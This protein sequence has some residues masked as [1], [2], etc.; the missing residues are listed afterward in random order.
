MKSLIIAEKPIVARDLARVLGKVPKHSKGEYFENDNY[1][2]ASAV[3]H[4]VE[5][6]MPNDIDSKL[7]AWSLKTLPILP[8]RFQLKP[9]DKTKAKFAELK[10]LLR[11]ADIDNVINACDAGREGELIFEYIYEL[12]GSKLPKKRLWMVSMTTDAI[13]SAFQQLREGE[14][15]QPLQHA[16]RCRSESDWLIGINGTRALTKSMFGMQNVATVGR[17][18]TPTLAMVVDREAEIRA[19][20]SRDFWRVNA[21]FSIKSG[22]YSGLYQKP[23]FKKGEDNHD[24][25][26]RLWSEA[27]ADAIAVAV[28]GGSAK[29]EE[30]CKRTRQTAPRL[31]DLTTLQ[32]EANGRFGFPA[33]KTLRVAQALYEKHKVLTYPRT[34]SKALPEDYGS[35]VR[36]VLAAFSGNLKSYANK[37]LSNNW[38]IPANKRIFNNAQVTDHFAI[39]PTGVFKAA[40]NDDESKLFDM[41]CRRFLAVFY[42]SAEYD[43]TTRLSIVGE[44][45]FKTEGKVLVESGW[46]EVMERNQK[47]DDLPALGKAD[48]DPAQAKIEAVAVEKDATRPPARYTEAT[49]LAAMETAGKLVEDEE[50]ADAMKESGLGTPATRAAT[51]EHL[52][53]EKYMLREG[54][55]LSPTPKAEELVEL[56][57]AIGAETLTSPVMTGDWEHRLNLMERGKL[58][59]EH[60][61]N[62][63]RALTQEL[64]KR[65]ISFQEKDEDL[66]RTDFISPTDGKPLLDS[67][68]YYKSQDGQLLINKNLGN[69]KLEDNEVR[70]LLKEGRIGPLDGF[71]SKKGRAFSAMLIIEDGKAK[72]DFGGDSKNG[73]EGVDLSEYPVI[74]AC[75]LD[76]APIHETANA[77]ICANYK[78]GNE[79]CPF[80][81]GRII[82]GRT[83]SQEEFLQLL[84]DKKTPLLKGFRSNRTKRLF[85]A[86]LVLDEKGKVGFD[87]PPRPAKKPVARKQAKAK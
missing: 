68:R 5:L 17:V 42:P 54:R 43:V 24:R 19:F 6:F 52:L 81:V 78:P 72:F 48:G 4:L 46:L 77:F 35:T 25:A 58:S 51:I 76:G 40:L 39:I 83:I 32:R 64:V 12:S 36:D 74:A 82:L 38:V 50:L 56:L 65:M 71:R 2:I 84:N 21:D 85:D 9:I 59:R 67:L 15:M 28:R 47:S 49:L 13:K 61:M 73:E 23:G 10:R 53:Y 34:S 75:P 37:I 18:Q 80:R 31:Y 41:V 14:E 86:Y 45:I 44:H 27:E 29:V 66:P 16:A 70:Q 26:E 1:V 55:E 7:K 79:G 60:F 30:S 69:R 33:G 62:D 20:R 87:F 3:G 63:I 11:R 57:K 8:D 22:I